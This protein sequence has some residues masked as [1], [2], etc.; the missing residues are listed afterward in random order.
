M[1]AAKVVGEGG[2]VIG[3]DNDHEALARLEGRA[4]A[5]G[6]RNVTLAHGD[7]EE[8]IPCEACADVVFFGICLHDFRDAG[9]VLANARRMVKPE[10]ILIDLDWKAE[11]MELGPPLR[12]RFP[13]EKAAGMIRGAGFSIESIRT[14]GPYH[15]LL[16]ARPAGS[17]AASPEEPAKRPE[18][19]DLWDIKPR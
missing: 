8:T 7:A 16:T 17:S 4:A 14:C 10:G 1:P 12:I 11:P 9:Q 6:L 13:E 15:Y 2:R 18:P 3:I 19:R 5:A